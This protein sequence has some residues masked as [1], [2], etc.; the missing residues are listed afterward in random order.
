MYQIDVRLLIRNT[1]L[2]QLHV[3]LFS[4]V[5]PDSVNYKDT[6]IVPSSLFIPIQ[7]TFDS[8]LHPS[9][10]LRRWIPTSLQCMCHTD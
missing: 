7:L 3:G 10:I 9:M 1:V 8:C 6:P 4:S 5:C 2:L